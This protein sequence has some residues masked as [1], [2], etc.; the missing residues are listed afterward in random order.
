MTT[1]IQRYTYRQTSGQTGRP[2]DNISLTM[3]GFALRAI[4]RKKIWTLIKLNVSY[5]ASEH[6]LIKRLVCELLGKIVSLAL[7]DI[8]IN[9][10]KQVNI[11]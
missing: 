5:H 3:P 7:L 1:V 6:G 9:A 10:S 4:A 2:T 8:L 11:L